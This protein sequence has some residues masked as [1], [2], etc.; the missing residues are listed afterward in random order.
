MLVIQAMKPMKMTPQAESMV[1]Q[2]SFDAVPLRR[3]ST[4]SPE[5]KRICF[6]RSLLVRSATTSHPCCYDRTNYRRRLA[7]TG[8]ESASAEARGDSGSSEG[9]VAKPAVG[10]VDLG[11]VVAVDKSH[12]TDPAVFDSV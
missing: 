3:F 1:V 2:T 12:P 9:R 7:P 8:R 5:G 11:C 6:T 4:Y 10:T